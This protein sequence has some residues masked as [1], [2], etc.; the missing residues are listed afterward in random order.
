[1]KKPLLKIFKVSLEESRVPDDWVNSIII[2]IYKKNKKPSMCASYRPINLT[3]SA[4]K[5]FERI[6]YLKIINYL[7][8][9]D[10]ISSSQH[11]FLSKKST[12]TNLLACTF[13]WV[14]YFNDKKACD[15]IYIDYE[16]AFDKV[17]HRKL[18]YKLGKLG[19]G[20]RLLSWV[21]FFITKR[22]QSVRV[23]NSYSQYVEVDSGVAQ[24]TLLGPLLFILYKLP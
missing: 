3:C 7:R 2:P 15:I 18:I 10:L 20:G 23:R 8:E 24:G 19:F 12:L 17:P 14:T 1:M 16:K 6:I 22:R 5:I 21:E 13:D 11:G 4:S 9:N